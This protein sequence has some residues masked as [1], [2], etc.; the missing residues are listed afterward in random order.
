MVDPRNNAH[1]AADIL[2]NAA[3]GGGIAE[4]RLA[5][6]EWAAWRDWCDGTV[7]GETRAQINMIFDG[8][9]DMDA[10]LQQVEMCGRAKIIPRGTSLVPVVEKPADPVAA[11]GFGN[12]ATGS[13]R[14]HWVR[15]AERSDAVEITYYDIDQ[16][17]TKQSYMHKGSGYDGLT[18]VPRIMRMEMR[19][20]NN[21]TQA[22]REAIIRQQLSESIKRID[23]R[24]TGIEGIPVVAGDIYEAV[25]DGNALAFSGR[26]AMG[27]LVSGLIDFDDTAAVDYDDTAAVEYDSGS[28]SLADSQ[29]AAGSTQYTGSTV[30]LDEEIEIPMSM[31][32]NAQLIVRD[33]DDTISTYTISGPFGLSTR[34]VEITSAGTFDFLSPWMIIRATDEVSQYRVVAIQ[35]TS[36]QDLA[37]TGAQY[38]ETA[39]YHS[40]YDAGATA[41]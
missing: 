31:S 21:R 26:L 3:Y 41:I 11:F 17:Y 4:N 1:A 32:G 25:S 19:G 27:P 28:D 8:E 13:Q 16:D 24:Q 6:T 36:N 29:G 35:R 7:D 14:T 15:Q 33:P 40:D 2:T 18:R 39:H 34:S 23:S 12:T 30:Y 5:S 10:A 38:D 37:I 9:Y 22:I 20:I